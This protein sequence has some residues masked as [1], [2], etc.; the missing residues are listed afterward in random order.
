MN[1]QTEAADSRIF[2][3]QSLEYIFLVVVE[4]CRNVSEMMSPNS[5]C[6]PL[7]CTLSSCVGT[8]VEAVQ[9]GRDV[10]TAE[11]PR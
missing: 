10:N 6:F 8:E 11:N 3:L 7:L 9:T 2:P 5:L 1:E 4:A